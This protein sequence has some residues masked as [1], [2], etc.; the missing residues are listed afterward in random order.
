MNDDVVANGGSVEVTP[1]SASRRNVEDA[2]II[3][4]GAT[5]NQLSQM[6]NMNIRM[7]QDTMKANA[8]PISRSAS[9]KSFCVMAM[10]ARSQ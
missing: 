9:V 2:F 10:L 3:T 7:V 6:F 8:V 4:R 1:K 5:A